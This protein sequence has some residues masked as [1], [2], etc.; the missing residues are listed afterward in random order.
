MKIEVSGNSTSILLIIFPLTPKTLKCF[1]RQTKYAYNFL[2]PDT[3]SAVDLE[4]KWHL[5]GLQNAE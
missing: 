1:I 3:V 2:V 4:Y 5:L